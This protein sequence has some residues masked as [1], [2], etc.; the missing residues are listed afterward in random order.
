MSDL[1]PTN[2]Q[3][4]AF[5]ATIVAT[6]G[7]NAADE[8]D[9][10]KTISPTP[11]VRP[12]GPDIKANV[13]TSQNTGSAQTV[14]QS[15]PAEATQLISSGDVPTQI[16]GAPA[17]KRSAIGAVPSE[18][19]SHSRENLARWSEFTVHDRV[20]KGG[21]GEIFRA[22]Q[23]ALQREVA[24]KKIIPEHLHSSN[25]LAMEQSFISEA[26][27]TGYLGHPNI[28]P[29]Y[30]LG[31]D[32]EGKWFFTMKMVCG[33]E[34]RH[35]L[36]PDKCK[37]EE[38]K[39]D[40]K[41]RNLSVDNPE[42]RAAHLEANLGILSSICNAVAFAHSKN[43]IHRD[44][45]PENVMVGAFGEVL[46]M[47]WGLAVDVSETPAPMGSPDKRVPSRAECGL[48]GTPSYMAPEQMA[49]DAGG[50]YTGGHLNCWT[51]VF[52]L[53]AMLYEVLAGSAPYSG[54][55]ISS[56][57]K[58]VA[59]CAPPALPDSVPAEL[60]AI[61]HKAM[62]KEPRDRFAD[63]LAFQTALTGFLQHR[64][65]ALIAAKA[66][67]E[68]CVQDIPSLARAVVLYDQALELWPG[69]FAAQEA[70]HRARI[71]LSRL[72]RRARVT[73]HSL[74]A[75][76]ACI[77]LGLTIGFVWIRNEQNKALASMEEE[78]KAKNAAVLSM[79]AEKQA[80]EKAIVAMH[81][82]LV[83]IAS[84]LAAQG[85]AY[86]MADRC[87]SGQARY[88]Q[89]WK[90]F[91]ELQEPTA[92]AEWGMWGL[93]QAVDTPLLT[94]SDTEL[95]SGAGAVVFSP[96]GKSALS[97][98]SDNSLRL[99][100]IATG[101]QLSA[102]KGHT[103]TVCCVAFAANGKQAV[104]GSLDG[105]V[106]VWDV[107]RGTQLRE[108]AFSTPLMKWVS[109]SQD[110]LKVL[111]GGTD[112]VIQKWELATGNEIPGPPRA[113]VIVMTESFSPETG[114]VLTGSNFNAVSLWDVDSGKLLR[115]MNRNT[116]LSAFILSV[117]FSSDGKR[118]LSGGRDKILRIWDL[119]KGTIL[120]ESAG[121][122][123]AISSVSF[124]A[125]G[126]RALSG[127][128][129]QT[130]KMW[131]AA[132]G[133]QSSELIGHTNK[134]VGAALSPDGRNVLSRGLDRTLRLWDTSSRF[135]TRVFK[136]HTSGLE[137]LA[138]SPDGKLALSG[139]RDNT[140]R[141]WDLESGVELRKMRGFAKCA[142]F[143]ADGKHAITGD[144]V[145]G[146]LQTWDLE[147]GL[148]S[149]EIK[150][151][152]KCGAFSTDG[153]FAFLTG[154]A[155]TDFNSTD[156]KLWDV[157]SGAVVRVFEGSSSTFYDTAIS[158][159]GGYGISITAEESLKIWNLATGKLHHEIKGAFY[160]AAF[161]PGGKRFVTGTI[162]GDVQTWDSE[163]GT[164]IRDFPGHLE[165]IRSV[166]FSPD[167][168]YIAAG[169]DGKTVKLWDVESGTEL[170][171]F[172][173]HESAVA[174][175]AFSGDSKR[176][177][178][179]GDD[180]VLKL[181]D[182]TYPARYRQFQSL[183]LSAQKQLRE[184]PQN[185]SALNTLGEWFAFRGVHDHAVAVL[186]SAR[187]NGAPVS[188]LTLG[189]CYEQL[190]NLEH[191]AAN[192]DAELSRI[193]ADP[194]PPDVKSRELHGANEM[195]LSICVRVLYSRLIDAPR[196]AKDHAAYIAAIQTY[197][198]I[199][200]REVKSPLLLA[201]KLN[202][203]A[204][205]LLTDREPAL[206]DTVVALPLA[207]RA[208]ELTKKTDPS[209]LDVLALA[210]FRNGM[211]D[212]ALTTIKKAI[213]LLPADLSPASR[214]EYEDQLNEIQNGK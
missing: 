99:W 168:K 14:I 214:K 47:D 66:E 204:W 34:W 134:V 141:I 22:G 73:R 85:D 206:R 162:S 61:C 60:A 205:T 127:S 69:N 138:I 70:L 197:L 169:S 153:K 74:I 23:N 35:L 159:E 150:A 54:Q 32:D 31:R 108:F 5:V 10:D 190:G 177:L 12:N 208:V 195:Y 174:S 145:H 147:S 3:V 170:R 58:Q 13:I 63:A 182:G 101:I 154:H 20:G 59:A 136:G 200:E 175:I 80:K 146:V 82:Q 211:K 123:S 155:L 81:A 212:E 171:E 213:A 19:D 139:A 49:T 157:E 121:H 45:K 46:V 183:L 18:R 71:L 43:V 119:E 194:I 96:N 114:H 6:V 1:L 179:G 210:L 33:I 160:R 131:D 201:D 125:D 144:N 117:A 15:N 176:I 4:Q 93:Y 103:N 124:S 126:R 36:H 90:Q 83:G 129:D 173:G 115:D 143:F 56:V 193:R 203:Y 88:E 109:F 100:D 94:L 24:I 68:S 107:E 51:D 39:Q 151:A 98:G 116:D 191:A 62:S 113:K 25:A 161:A 122:N 148:K 21:M 26:V 50:N 106:R 2:P 67:C 72:E 37:N 156:V 104:S 133:I 41:S 87:T 40:A 11:T 78:K 97:A 91:E 110:G 178:T 28:V 186:E 140:I 118:G 77:V 189:R 8:L 202:Q 17:A 184:N 27:V 48:G 128:W 102:L 181:W 105:S 9:P 167:G 64:E 57:L 196:A 198:K 120:H 209:P 180:A 166:A 95:P 111:A 86:L 75:A 130:L 152:F 199:F 185:P 53:G 29:V 89:A 132:T 92:R 52:L 76:V 42:F 207:R 55:S 137:C 192:Y 7:A 84:G 112:G 165:T 16:G 164:K 135:T 142:A 38:M 158:A 188:G 30:S 79:A 163:T 44:L 172:K 187:S 65:S 149:R